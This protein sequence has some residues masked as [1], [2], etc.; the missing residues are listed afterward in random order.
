MMR[1]SRQAIDSWAE[2]LAGRSL[3]NLLE[4]AKKIVAA[5]LRGGK[6]VVVTG[7]GPNLHEGVTTLIAE[8]MHKRVIDGVITSSAVVAH[9]MG[10]TLDRV[11]RVHAR[12][13][14]AL[15]LAPAMLPRG[16]VFE[17]T[18]LNQEQRRCVTPEVEPWWDQY[19][20]IS[21]L[22]GPVIL[23][24]AGNMAWPMGPRTEC[25]AREAGELARASGQLLE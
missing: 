10:G 9:E 4:A 20:R 19:D 7:S 1:P 11:K 15:P 24:A 25:L 23:K 8:L 2:S 21:E 18:M 14:P 5:K 12:D 6:V 3:A 17:I 22:P 16:G 13:C